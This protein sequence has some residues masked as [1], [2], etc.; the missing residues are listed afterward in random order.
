MP[1]RLIPKCGHRAMIERKAEFKTL[2]M[3]FMCLNEPTFEST[4]EHPQKRP[5]ASSGP[6]L[7]TSS[8]LCYRRNTRY[9]IGVAVMCVFSSNTLTF[10]N[11]R[12]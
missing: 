6:F 4:S 11:K 3:D 7:F 1:V 8:T 5:A 10:S 2:M 12:S 9:F